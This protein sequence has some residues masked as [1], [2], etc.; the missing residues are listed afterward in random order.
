MIPQNASRLPRFLA[1]FMAPVDPIDEQLDQLR[2][3]GAGMARIAHLCASLLVIL[4]SAGSFVALGSDALHSVMQGWQR[5]HTI[6]V[7]NAISLAVSTLMVACM[8]AALISAAA[9]LR[10]LASRRAQ[11]RE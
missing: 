11:F 10:L 6:D 3:Q 7:P 1:R 2:R 5:S 4:F 8:D 9:S